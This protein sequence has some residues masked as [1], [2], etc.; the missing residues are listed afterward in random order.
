[1]LGK[2]RQNALKQY[3]KELRSSIKQLESCQSQQQDPE[4]AKQLETLDDVE[5]QLSMY[6]FIYYV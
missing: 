1:M 2:L 3:A 6:C 5:E 4:Y